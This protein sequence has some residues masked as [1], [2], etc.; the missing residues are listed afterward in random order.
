MLVRTTQ[1]L[2]E[3]LG[4][5]SATMHE[6][7]NAD[8]QC[9]YSG[10]RCTKR[11]NKSEEPYPV[12]SVWRWAGRG[13]NRKPDDMVV[14]CPVRFSEDSLAGDVSR[15]VWGSD[16]PAELISS[17]SDVKFA[18]LGSLNLVL[19]RR[20]PEAGD[21][22]DFVSVETQAIDITGSV[23]EAYMAHGSGRDQICLPRYG[24]NTLNALKRLLTQLA[25]K[26][27]VHAGWGKKI[28]VVVQDHLLNRIRKLIPEAIIPIADASI[29]FLPY[30]FPPYVMHQGQEEY[31]LTA[32]DPVG[33]TLGGLMN[34]KLYGTGG[35]LPQFLEAL[36]QRLDDG[37]EIQNGE[38]GGTSPRP[39]SLLPDSE[40]LILRDGAPGTKN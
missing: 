36:R 34:A 4:C 31:H 7:V 18:S 6:P 38:H 12:C 20:D 13:R 39:I 40:C 1:V 2:G 35:G 9:P 26:G 32:G 22:E 10:K 19:V 17:V 8:Y 29:I 25:K 37:C 33:A 16:V 11:G 21:I 27:A 14:V 5:P 3:V 28:V 30:Q 23:S 24:F 15:I